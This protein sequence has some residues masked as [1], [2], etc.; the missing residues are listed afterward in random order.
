METLMTS[1]SIQPLP[2]PV[3]LPIPARRALSI[4]QLQLWYRWGY[5][6]HL[7][8]ALGH[9]PRVGAGA[10]FGRIMHEVIGHMYRGAQMELA[11]QEVWTRECGPVWDD[12]QR[13]IG[14]DAAYAA[15]GRPTT[16]AA[17]QWRADHPAYDAILERIAD[18]QRHALT[19]YRWGKTQSLADY[20]RRAVALLACEGDILLSAPILIEGIPTTA[21]ERPDEDDLPDTISALPTDSDRAEGAEMDE[22]GRGTRYQL[23]T[24]T[25]AGIDVVGVPDVLARDADGTLCVADYKTGTPHSRD[26]LAENAQ[27]AI[28][29]ELLRQNGYITEDDRVQ[30]G[31]I[32]LTEDGVRAIWADTL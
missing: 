2:N 32:Y 11:H 27:L 5:A 19:S 24:G 15:H 31:H 18:H 25:I 23:L 7:R 8:Y 26:E 22:D 13:L 6:R 1:D 16:S 14:L 4:S 20:Y 17:K 28:Y 30:I 9:S 29:V 21:L 12:L 10:W 3:E